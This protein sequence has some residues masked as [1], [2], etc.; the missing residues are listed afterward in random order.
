MQALA[1]DK[2]T[3]LHFSKNRELLHGKCLMVF[4]YF[5]PFVS[6]EPFLYPL[7]ISENRRERV[8]KGW[9]GNEW[10]NNRYFL[11]DTN[12]VSLSSSAEPNNQPT[13]K[14]RKEI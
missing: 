1:F 10:V 5:N 13:P 9:I 8:E 6:N 12:D 14:R 3:N 11:D 4:S 7:K 2:I